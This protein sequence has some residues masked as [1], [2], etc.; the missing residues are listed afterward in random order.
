MK[1]VAL[2]MERRKGLAESGRGKEKRREE[3]K[4]K[5]REVKGT[6]LGT[7]GRPLERPRWEK[8]A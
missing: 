3:K 6:V 5:D 2:R 7:G 1:G 4:K 8:N